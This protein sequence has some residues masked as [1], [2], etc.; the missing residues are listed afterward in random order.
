M[1][2]CLLS[3]M[4]TSAQMLSTASH[5]LQPRKNFWNGVNVRVPLPTFC[6]DWNR[7]DLTFGRLA[8]KRQMT[9]YGWSQYH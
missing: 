4:E 1:R 9:D 6:L 7:V 3:Q 2:M 8:G 5:S